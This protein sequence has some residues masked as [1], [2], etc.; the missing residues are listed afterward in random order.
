[1]E[2][3]ITICNFFGVSESEIIHYDLA[4]GK[5]ITEFKNQKNRQNGKPNGKPNGKASAQKEE[6]NTIVTEPPGTYQAGP[7][8]PSLLQKQVADQLG[9]IALQADV[10]KSLQSAL[11]ATQSRLE[12]CLMQAASMPI[13]GPSTPIPAP[14]LTPL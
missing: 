5:L 11:I 6:N 1:M 14:S 8:D 12:A 2:D 9:I 7:T 3:L 10:I 13:S 4:E